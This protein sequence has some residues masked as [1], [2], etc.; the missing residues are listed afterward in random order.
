MKW[1]SGHALVLAAGRGTRLLPVT[2]FV[3]KPLFHL[4][5]IPSIELVVQ[6]L[7]IPEIDIISVNVFHL[8]EQILAWS[9]SSGREDRIRILE[10]QTLLGTGGAVK[11]A[12]EHLGYHRPLL[13]YNA[14]IL[15]SVDPSALLRHY[16]ELGQPASLLCL[17]KRS[18][19]NKLLVRGSDI[20]SF[21]APGRDALAYTGISVISPDLFR[22]VPLEPASLVRIWEDAIKEGRP[23]KAVRAEE[24]KF[25][26]YPAWIW[27]DIGT[28]CGYLEANWKML[29]TRHNAETWISPTAQTGSWLKLKG[30][31]IIGD[32]ADIGDNVFIKDSVIWPDIKIEKG[33]WIENTVVT[34]HGRLLCCE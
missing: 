25:F 29:K 26:G 3:P 21:S 6:K 9:R 7:S 4:L 33:S 20:V 11:N 18:P 8:K 17:H 24:A 13:V 12:F 27:E 32:G 28:P 10:E 19:F 22:D 15:C 2:D 34:P 31:V 14:D 30:R 23:I 1:P 16:F 5:D